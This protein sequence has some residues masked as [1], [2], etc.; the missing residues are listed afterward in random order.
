[1]STLL[2]TVVSAFGF[3]FEALDQS[4]YQKVRSLTFL[5]F[6]N[7]FLKAYTRLGDWSFTT[8]LLLSVLILL[9]KMQWPMIY[10]HAL[11]N[12]LLSFGVYWVVKNTVRRPRPF[13]KYQKVAEVPPLDTFSFPSGHTMNNLAIGYTLMTYSPWLGAVAIFFPITC[14]LLRV[15]YNVHYLTDVI[16]GLVLGFLCAWLGSFLLAWA[17]V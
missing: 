12:T 14:G 10:S 11:L 5:R 13:V 16:G 2:S 7:S 9:P 15:Y 17:L 1:M 6:G 8:I 4:F 3:W